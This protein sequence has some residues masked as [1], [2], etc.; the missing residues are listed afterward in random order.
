VLEHPPPDVVPGPPS[1]SKVSFIG[2]YF[3]SLKDIQGKLSPAMFQG[4]EEIL[5]SV[6]KKVKV[7]TQIPIRGYLLSEKEG[8]I[9]RISPLI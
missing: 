2:F 9:Y 4:M 1:R 6:Y 7:T 3:E 5:E 8:F